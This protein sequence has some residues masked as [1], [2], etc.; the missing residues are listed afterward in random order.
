MKKGVLFNAPLSTVVAESGHTDQICVCDAGLPIPADVKRI[1]LALRAGVPG[2][3][4]TVRTLLSEMVVEQVILATELPEVS[5]SCHAHLLHL[6]Q[7]AE[8]DQGKPIHIK[9]LS[10]EEFK[11]QTH[12]CKAIVRTGEVTPYANLIL[13]AGVAF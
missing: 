12:G 7:E 9:Y 11:Q 8:Q 1:D 10:H 3:L 13:C 6:L 2:F 4:E 5:A